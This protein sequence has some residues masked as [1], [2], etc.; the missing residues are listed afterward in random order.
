M[1]IKSVLNIRNVEKDTPLWLAICALCILTDRLHILD[2]LE[3]SFSSKYLKP[4]L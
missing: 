3:L 2:I 1:H 4:V